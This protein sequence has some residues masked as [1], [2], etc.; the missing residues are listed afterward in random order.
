MR[1]AHPAIVRAV[2]LALMASSAC[3]GSGGGG[4]PTGSGQNPPP[5]GQQPP[6]SSSSSI[7]VQNNRFNPSTTTVT[8]NTTVVWTWDACRD[9]GYGGQVCA[10]H[11][12][13]FD[14]G[15]GGSPTQST[16]SYSR[17][18]AAAGTFNYHC[19]VHGAVMTG[20]VVVR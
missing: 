3:G 17:Q 13:T 8:V 2:V 6:P 15:A 7:T 10:D 14:G 12:V 9:D 16:G 19:T 18:F 20:Q 11:N 5:G 4:Y 1:P